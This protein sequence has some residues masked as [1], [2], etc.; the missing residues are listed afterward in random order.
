MS[1]RNHNKTIAIDIQNKTQD[2]SI[3]SIPSLIDCSPKSVALLKSDYNLV[4]HLRDVD[5]KNTNRR[6]IILNSDISN[7]CVQ[8]YQEIKIA[9]VLMADL[10]ILIKLITSKLDT[11]HRNSI[12]Q[13]SYSSIQHQVTISVYSILSNMFRLA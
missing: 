9:N 7:K 10:N 3:Y 13:T 6:K 5:L 1:G 12:F 8:Y 2:I 11:L 4:E